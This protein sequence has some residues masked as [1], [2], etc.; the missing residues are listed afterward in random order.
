M[1]TYRY[2]QCDVLFG[3][4]NNIQQNIINNI[5][6]LYLTF[7][8]AKV[9]LHTYI[10]NFGP[11]NC[12]TNGDSYVDYSNT[13]YIYECMNEGN[14]DRLYSVSEAYHP[15]LHVPFIQC[16]LTIGLLAIY[17]LFFRIYEYICPSMYK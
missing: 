4:K 10:Q 8:I 15:V 11:I 3:R 1:N 7:D 12:M 16:I 2:F 5:Y 9:L 13:G 14:P 17:N 6:I